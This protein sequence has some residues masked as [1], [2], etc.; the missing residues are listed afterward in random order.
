MENDSYMDTQK[1]SY[2]QLVGSDF[3]WYK[4]RR[5]V[6]LNL[7]IFLLLVTSTANGYDGSMMN[8]L[9]LIDQWEVSFNH[10]SGSKLGLLS[11]IQNI[12]TVGSQ[13][14]SPYLCDG[15]G[16]KRTIFIG[17]VLMV[18]AAVIQTASQTVE[19]FIG[20]RFLL[21]FGLGICTS[22]AP[23]LVTELAHPTQRG[24]LS[25]VYNAFWPVG[26]VVYVTGYIDSGGK[27]ITFEFR[28]SWVTF[29]TFHINNSWSW[30]I[31]SAAQAL[32][33][34]LQ[35]FLILLCPESPR[36]LISKGRDSEALQ[37]LAYYHANGSTLDP[38]VLFEFQEIKTAI[39][40]EREQKQTGWIQLVRTPGNRRRMRIIIAIALFSQ[41]SGNGIAAFYGMA[42]SP[43]IVLYTLEILPFSIRAKGY[44]IFAF[45]V[46]A[47]LVFNQYINPVALTAMGWKYYIVY[48]AWIGFELGYVYLFLVETRNR[49]L[50]ETAL[51]FDGLYNSNNEV[52]GKISETQN[53]DEKET[54]HSEIMLTNP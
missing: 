35:V 36:W 20:A 25:S 4:S 13:P 1:T 51:I 10:P 29:G 28:A 5:I 38:L 48:C 14:I 30:R 37:V 16:R 19:M 39:E 53:K 3:R 46:S 43:L 12:G 11:A 40:K 24:P 9:Q 15:L 54:S 22:A 34:L 42:Y 6:I 32:P 18:A 33:S 31:P 2:Q 17:A 26:A 7:W 49:T 45:T 44:A 41:W 8:G 47:S 21:G 50:E 27:K 23:L 52:T